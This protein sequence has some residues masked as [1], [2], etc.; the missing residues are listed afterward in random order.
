[1]EDVKICSSCKRELPKSSFYANSKSKDGLQGICIECKKAMSR[2][3]QKRKR[4]EKGNAEC[5]EHLIPFYSK[6]ELAKFTPRELMLE[7]KARGFR[8]EYMIE[9]QRRIMFD[10]LK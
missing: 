6:P 9:P 8:W 5:N 7:L 4:S 3:Y 10:K 1:M 2:E